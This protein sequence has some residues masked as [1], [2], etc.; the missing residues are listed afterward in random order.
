[1][2]C[3]SKFNLNKDQTNNVRRGQFCH[4]YVHRACNYYA[5]QC[6][7]EKYADWHGP[8]LPSCLNILKIKCWQNINQALHYLF[9]Y[10]HCASVCVIVYLWAPCHGSECR[11]WLVMVFPC[12][13]AGDWLPALCSLGVGG[14]MPGLATRGP[15]PPSWDGHHH[16]HPHRD[17][18]HHHRDA[19]HR[20]HQ[21]LII[22]Q[23]T[24]PRP[25][26]PFSMIR[27]QIFI[28]QF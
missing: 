21:I 9:L 12:L 2:H 26:Q 27:I 1:M 18:H 15:G 22:I 23:F 19:F 16:H 8:H 14:W 11:W 7:V 10:C 25:R 4:L 3:R 6:E 13:A 28:L 20:W 24:T 5:R 17:P